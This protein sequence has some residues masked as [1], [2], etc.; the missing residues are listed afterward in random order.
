MGRIEPKVYDNWIETDP[1]RSF[2][3]WNRLIDIRRHTGNNY[4]VRFDG[5]TVTVWQRRNG[6]GIWAPIH[7]FYIPGLTGEEAWDEFYWA[8]AEQCEVPF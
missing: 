7:E 1:Y 4:D 5:P 3:L 6:Y 2:A 8:W